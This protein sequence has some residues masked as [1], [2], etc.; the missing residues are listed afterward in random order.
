[1]V[2]TKSERSL[3]SED[4]TFVDYANKTILKNKISGNIAK[5][6]HLIMGNL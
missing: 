3:L 1:M 5:V 2:Y 4:S 6:Y